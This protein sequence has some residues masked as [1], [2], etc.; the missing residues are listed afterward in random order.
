MRQ[1]LEPYEPYPNR[2][3]G[4]LALRLTVCILGGFLAVLVASF[5][6]PGPGT[7]LWVFIAAE[8]VLCFSLLRPK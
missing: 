5:F 6:V 2:S 8:A 7:L 1:S 3:I 4:R